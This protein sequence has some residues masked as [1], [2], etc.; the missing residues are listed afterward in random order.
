MLQADLVH[1]SFVGSCCNLWV[2]GESFLEEV[3]GAQD[4]FYVSFI[5]GINNRGTGLC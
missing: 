5:S 3:S 4:V 1:E 2:S